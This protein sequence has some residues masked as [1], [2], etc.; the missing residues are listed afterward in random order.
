M[1]ANQDSPKLRFTVKAKNTTLVVSFSG[2][3]TDGMEAALSECMRAV[4][5]HT[6]AKFVV[7][8]LAEVTNA[9]PACGRS[10]SDFQR[11]MRDGRQIFLC[12]L[13]PSVEKVLLEADALE[14][15]ECS[16]DFLSA[17][18]AVLKKRKI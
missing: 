1:L 13:R 18:Q 3:L 5:A 14:P 16:P 6:K 7:M 17:L 2:E 15:A 10:F 9:A 4:R 12:S 11:A 8:D